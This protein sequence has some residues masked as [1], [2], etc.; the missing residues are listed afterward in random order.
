VEANLRERRREALRAEE[1]IERETD[2]L[3]SRLKMLELGPTIAALQEK[4]HSIRA[5]EWEKARRRLRDLTPEE[6]QA[7]EEMSRATVNK[8]L[9]L[10]ISQLKEL[11]RQPD[12]LKLIEFLRRTF[13]LK[14]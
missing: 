11:A 10:P 12:G 2:I 13:Q 5:N 9:H 1:I 3:L 8:I 4:L 7:I 14:D 6:A